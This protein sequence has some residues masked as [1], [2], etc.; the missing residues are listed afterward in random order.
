MKFKIKYLYGHVEVCDEW[1]RFIFS[2]DNYREAMEEIQ[3]RQAAF[4][5]KEKESAA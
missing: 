3:K 4:I 5:M 2:A 1:D